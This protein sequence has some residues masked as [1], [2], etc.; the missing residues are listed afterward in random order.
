MGHGMSKQGTDSANADAGADL[1]AAVLASTDDGADDLVANSARVL[2]G[3][4]VDGKRVVAR[5]TWMPGQPDVIVCT[6]EPQT[7][8]QEMRM[9]TQSSRQAGGVTARRQLIS[10]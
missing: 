2:R 7:P 6:H 9:S 5:R 8:Q 3:M 4:S 10:P 1:V